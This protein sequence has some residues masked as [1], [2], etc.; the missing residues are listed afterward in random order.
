MADNADGSII[1]DTEIDTE[2][3]Q[4]GSG[5]LKA[6]I[7]SL[8]SSASSTGEKIKSSLS[9]K[10]AGAA[11]AIRNR[12]ADLQSKLGS[13]SVPSAS[14]VVGFFANMAKGA[15]SA[16]GHLLK[17]AGTGALRFLGR[18]AQGAKNAGIQLLKMVGNA[19]ANGI[20][21]IGSLAASSAKAL[22][23]LGNSAKKSGEG[24][25]SG[26][27]NALEIGF[28]IASMQAIFDKEIGRAHV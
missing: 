6:A 27:K 28:G 16:T 11:E 2:G 12:L 22:L 1:V 19:A 3:F 21:K 24:L 9:E 13:I 4:S 7:A 8:L 10:F 23:G 15:A 20:K 18:L 25:K 14:G 17:M 5:R 26:L